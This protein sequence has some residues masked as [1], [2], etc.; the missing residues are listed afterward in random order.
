MI[1][2]TLPFSCQTV[3]LNNIYSP[4][5]KQRIHLF[6]VNV[7]VNTTSTD[8]QL[9]KSGAVSSSLLKIGGIT[10]QQQCIS[11]Y[12]SG[13]QYGQVA[14]TN[15]GQ[16]QCSHIYHGA[17]PQYERDGT[18]LKVSALHWCKSCMLYATYEKAEKYNENR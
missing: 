13:I 14:V 12:P 15:G 1:Q 5:R 10:I 11:S 9:N 7:I 16:L 18:A 2:V 8:L 17:L 4:T 6:Q 3:L